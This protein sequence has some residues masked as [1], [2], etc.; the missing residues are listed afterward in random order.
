MCECIFEVATSDYF[1]ITHYLM[2]CTT[3]FLIK[4]VEKIK[5]IKV[6][7]NFKEYRQQLKKDQK[8]KSGVYCLVNLINGNIYIG[9]SC[10]K[11]SLLE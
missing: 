6:Y 2:K 11:I 8:D 3:C 1:T 10:C 4:A 5:P 9:S 7:D